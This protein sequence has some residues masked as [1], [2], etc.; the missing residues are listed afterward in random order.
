M[1]W[2]E[3]ESKFK[4]KSHVLVRQKKRSLER[5]EVGMVIW[6]QS[7]YSFKI[8]SKWCFKGS[9]IIMDVVSG[10]PSSKV[11]GRTMEGGTIG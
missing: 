3:I 8:Q 2:R 1:E 9:K 11:E 6:A 10:L 7:G 5:I 4:S